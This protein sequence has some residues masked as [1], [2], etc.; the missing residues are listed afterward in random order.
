MAA[1][2]SPRKGSLQYW[3]RKRISKFLPSVNWSAL[4]SS[5]PLKG[6]ICY[7]AGMMSAYV[8]DETPD[9]MTKGKKIIVPVTILEC[10]SMKIFSVRL[11]K[12]GI[13]KTE[14]LGDNLDKELKRV[15][16]LPKENKN[17]A[18]KELEKI[19]PENYDE[20]RIICYSQPK[21]AQ[22]KKTPDLVEVGLSGS[23]SEKLS[24]VKERIGKEI[25]VSD[26]F[27]KGQLVDTRG[28]TKGKGLCGPVKRM[29]LS[30]KSHKSEKGVRR[31]GSLGPW[32]PRRVTFRVAQAGQVG[33][34]TRVIYNN[35][36]LDVGKAGSRKELTNIKNYGNVNSDFVIVQGSVQGTAKR[37]LIITQPLRVTK[38][39]NKKSLEL[40]E[41]R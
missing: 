27:E 26:F 41:I 30:L 38:K 29:G 8:K 12:H 31:P 17:E 13:V 23:I 22:I 33:L 39:Q 36:V 35:K 19:K 34:F 5:K 16:K 9:S 20:L 25:Y 18:I 24:F 14:V 32:H 7:K 28:L 37:Q 10:P 3:P 4:N 15:L 1:P 21:K 40:I 11:Y 6:F 2:K